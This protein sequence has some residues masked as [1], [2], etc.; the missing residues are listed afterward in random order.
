MTIRSALA[1]LLI[2]KIHHSHGNS[3]PAAGGEGFS[4]LV[5]ENHFRNF[6][7]W[8]EEDIARRDDLGFERIYRAKRAIDRYNQERNNFI[9]E[10]DKV[11]VAELMGISPDPLTHEVIIDRGRRDGV[12][13]GQAVLDAFGLMGQVVEVHPSSSRVL[14]I[15]DNSHALP[16]QINRNGVRAVAEGTG[17][18]NRLRLRHVSN[19]TDIR[20][21]DLLISSGLGERYPAGY[22]VAEVEEVV[23]DPGQSFATVI[24]RPKA[25]LDRSRHVLLVFGTDDAEDN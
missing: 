13:R 5:Q 15:T 4:R 2:G 7:L 1:D 3:A 23:R 9:E 16:V 14:L 10:M 19:T 6:Q 18:L 25:Q 12:Y 24:A 8:H 11:L 20:A 17:D 22:P 21:G